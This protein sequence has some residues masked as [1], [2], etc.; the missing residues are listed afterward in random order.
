M[1]NYC[2]FSFLLQNTTNSLK[3]LLTRQIKNNNTEITRI[4]INNNKIAK[5]LKK[6]KGY[7]TTIF[8]K[9]FDFLTNQHFTFLSDIVIK[10]VK[11]FLSLLKIDISAHPKIFVAGLGNVNITADSLGILVTNKIISTSFEIE[12]KTISDKNFAN[13]FSIAPSV[14]T[15]NGV[16]TSQIIKAICQEFKPDLVV[17]IDSLSCK[18]IEILGKTFQLSTSGLT[19]GSEVGLSQPKI[20]KQLL[21]VPVLT[22]GCPLVCNLKNI[23]KNTTDSRI[24]TLKDI[25]IVVK[26]CADIIAYSLNKCFHNLKKDEILF[27]SKE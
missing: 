17:L 6:D 19:P 13:V 3:G 21:K 18:D 12:N 26:K 24:L 4:K 2:E 11:N 5:L 20:N 8:C 14:A 25:D 1:N 10:E 15:Y 9:E 22:I 27:L 7:Y 16:Y 23:N